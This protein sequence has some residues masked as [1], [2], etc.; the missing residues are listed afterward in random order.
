VLAGRRSQRGNS[1]GRV[2]KVSAACEL[3]RTSSRAGSHTSRS[4]PMWPGGATAAHG[5]VGT[6]ASVK[7][8]FIAVILGILWAG[9]WTASR[10]AGG[11]LIVVAV[12][13][14]V[15]RPIAAAAR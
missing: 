1:G 12:G 4:A 7:P 3:A 15:V 11:A 2:S 13:D 14:V 9:P 8:R 10:M 6:Y 5:D